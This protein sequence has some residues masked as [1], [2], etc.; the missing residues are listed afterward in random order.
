MSTHALAASS[1]DTGGG[2]GRLPGQW[3]VS[4]GAYPM[5]FDE[6]PEEEPDEDPGPIDHPE[7]LEPPALP[8]W[9]EPPHDAARRAKPI[10]AAAVGGAIEEGVRTLGSWP[11][12]GVS[13]EGG[14]SSR[15]S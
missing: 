15:R 4:P 5:R 3:L 10:M 12:T 6:A 7:P 2:I 8:V 11:A 14:A 1:G 13:V 9:E